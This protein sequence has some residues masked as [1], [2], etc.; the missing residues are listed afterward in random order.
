M[1]AVPERGG[2]FDAETL[3][4]DRTIAIEDRIFCSYLD[5]LKRLHYFLYQEAVPLGSLGASAIGM[6]DL[7]VLRHG[8]PG[9]APTVGEWN[10]VEQQTQLLFQL[11][12]PSLRR[13]FLMSE[14]PWV[15]ALLPIAF[16]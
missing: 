6:G 16:L 5:R 13:K 1:D 9:R 14:T 8:S 3:P 10:K 2:V 4:E 12:T 15:V 7:N 11:L